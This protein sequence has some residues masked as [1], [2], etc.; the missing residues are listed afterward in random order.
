MCQRCQ[1]S[2]M[3]RAKKGKSKFFGSE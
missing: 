1:N 2:P 3:L